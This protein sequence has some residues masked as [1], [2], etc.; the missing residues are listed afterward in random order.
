MLTFPNIDPIAFEIGP[1]KIHW[2]GIAYMVGIYIAWQVGMSLLRKYQTQVTPKILDDSIIWIIMGIVVGGRLGYVLFYAPS[3]IWTNP[4]EIFKTWNGGMAF[5]GGTLGVLIAIFM[6]ARK[7]KTP[8]LSLLDIAAC[9]T[10]IGLF[11][12]RIANFIN[13][14]LWGRVT[15]SP[16]GMIFPRAGDLPRHPSQL[17]EAATEGVLLFFI[18]IFLW[19]KTDLRHK[20]GRIS[21]IFAIGYAMA[22]MF[23]ELFR[24]PDALV[25]GSLTI[26]QA[27]SIPLIG[28]GWFLLRYPTELF[29]K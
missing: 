15:N 28:A 23:C 7:V 6:Y 17:Y 10:P 4:L 21:G 1:F 8:F 9:V 2:Y 26:G 18:L 11:C 3:M 25:V 27:L 16:L 19:T 12:G 20:P 22:R 14:E 13:G 5:H 24:E 29:R